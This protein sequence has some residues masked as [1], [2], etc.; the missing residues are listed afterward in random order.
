MLNFLYIINIIDTFFCFKY[1]I[2]VFFF[3]RVKYLK[4]FTL[5]MEEITELVK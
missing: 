2:F 4:I 5:Y 1:F 3:F